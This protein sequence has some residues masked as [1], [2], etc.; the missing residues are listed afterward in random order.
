MGYYKSNKPKSLKELL[1]DYIEDFPHRKQLKRGMI[2]SKW[3]EIV[4]I[5][6]AEQV[7]RIHFK[8]DMLIMHVKNPAWRHEIHM[9]RY[10]IAKRLNDEVGEKIIKELRVQS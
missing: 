10:S 8:G 4:G 7:D 1:G 9:N 5:K 2:L 6:I 3:E